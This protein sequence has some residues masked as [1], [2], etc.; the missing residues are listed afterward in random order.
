MAV[1]PPYLEPSSLTVG[2]I[3]PHEHDVAFR[4]VSGLLIRVRL[5]I[6]AC[7]SALVPHSTTGASWASAV[8]WDVQSGEA[9]RCALTDVVY[10][11]P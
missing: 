7:P 10:A 5:V 1:N 9:F 8:N 3:S 11:L 2:M 4:I 6:E